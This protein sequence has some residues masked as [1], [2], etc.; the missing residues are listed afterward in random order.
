MKYKNTYLKL[1]EIA[2][3]GNLDKIG[4]I[5]VYRGT[6]EL[7]VKKKKKHPQVNFE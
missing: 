2:L 5:L 1:S 3:K 4:Q 6:T 7:T